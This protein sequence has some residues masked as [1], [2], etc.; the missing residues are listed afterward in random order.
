L[1]YSEEQLTFFK[2]YLPKQGFSADGIDTLGKS[3]LKKACD[4]Y[5]QHKKRKSDAEKGESKKTV[6]LTQKAHDILFNLAKKYGV[7]MSQW[8][9][10][11]L[12]ESLFAISVITSH[13]DN[14]ETSV[15]T[16]HEDNDESSVIMSHED[17]D[18]SSVIMSHEDNDETSVI[19]SHEK[20]DTI[21][22]DSETMITTPLVAT[23][24]K[25]VVPKAKYKSEDFNIVIERRCRLA[26]GTSVGH[27]RNGDE[28]KRAIYDA[29]MNCRKERK[30]GEKSYAVIYKSYLK[31]SNNEYFFKLTATKQ[32]ELI[33]AILESKEEGQRAYPDVIDPNYVAK[34][35]RIY[36]KKQEDN[37]SAN[38]C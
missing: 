12:N 37:A 4:A 6:N 32:C 34:I 31:I 1:K 17:N 25:K 20:N 33:A 27:F 24:I 36:L 15:I 13:E 29:V 35:I 18:E 22:A 10:N 8:I 9:E 2:E 19:T 5:R 3:D 11:N 23:S 28:I 21:V 38:G 30:D 16:S 26:S 7:T 14:D